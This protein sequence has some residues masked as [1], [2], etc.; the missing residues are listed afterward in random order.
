MI[1]DSVKVIDSQDNEIPSRVELNVDENQ[2]LTFSLKINEFQAI[3]SK[4]KVIDLQNNILRFSP[5]MKLNDENQQVEYIL[6]LDSEVKDGETTSNI[7]TQNVS[8]IKTQT[9]DDIV[10][11]SVNPTTN[12]KEQRKEEINKAFIDSYQA[13]LNIH[14]IQDRFFDL[15]GCEECPP[16][17]PN[18]EKLRK[19]Y[20]EEITKEG[21]GC[22]TCRKNGIKQ[23]YRALIYNLIKIK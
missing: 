3:L 7:S 6:Q 20:E 8:S 21:P 11:S 10:V 2:N 18:C 17:I 22:S 14:Q 5:L 12:T 15:E 13:Q 16:E 4:L 9:N 1:I 19:S 23:K